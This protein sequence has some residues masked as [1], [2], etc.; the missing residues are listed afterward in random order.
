MMQNRHARYGFSIALCV[1]LSFFAGHASAATDEKAVLVHTEAGDV[2]LADVRA[3]LKTLPA[4]TQRTMLHNHDQ[5]D[6]LVRLL[7]A[8]KLLLKEAEDKGWDKHPEVVAAMDAA[9]QNT[10]L[11]SYLADKAAPSKGYPSEVEI[12]LTYEA[13]RANFVT[14]RKFH[15]AQIFIASPTTASAKDQ[16]EAQVRLGEVMA[17][18]KAPH[19]DFAAIAASSS[20]DAASSPKKGDLGFL[21]EP[22]I[23]PKLHDA[24]LPLAKDAVSDPIRLNDGWHVVKVLDIAPASTQPLSEIRD[25][26]VQGLRERKRMADE[27]SYIDNLTK[28]VPPVN[29]A[30][31]GELINSPAQ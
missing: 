31:L 21:P 20:E 16:D 10:V 29:A 22:Q 15:L 18:L 28:K 26:I 8:Q 14:P 12:E 25:Q 23:D 11:Q 1:A 7:A 4:Q 9:R 6:N 27:R 19:A 17:K 13:N 30:V 5:L 2:T 24:I 3:N